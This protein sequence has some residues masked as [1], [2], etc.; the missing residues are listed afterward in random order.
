MNDNNITL[1]GLKKNKGNFT[2][3]I[4]E[5]YKYVFSQPGALTAPINYYRCMFK[6]MEMKMGSKKIDVPI[7]IIWVS[8]RG[9]WTQSVHR[10]IAQCHKK[11][12][13]CTKHYKIKQG[14]RNAIMIIIHIYIPLRVEFASSVWVTTD[15]KVISSFHCQNIRSKRVA[16]ASASDLDYLLC[17]Q[18]FSFCITMK[19]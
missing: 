1:Q 14:L 15:L 9:G 7:L 3:E 19:T 11:W 6:M 12:V 13:Y 17:A 8:F 16:W 10:Y 2:A 18:N 5:A 4:V